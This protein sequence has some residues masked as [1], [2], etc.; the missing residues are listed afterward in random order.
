MQVLI[1]IADAPCH[2]K[3]FHNSSVGDVYPYGDPKG[4][5]L[6]NLMKKIADS[7]IHYYFGYINKSCTLLMI[8]AFNTSLQA[9]SGNVHSVQQ[10]DAQD[11]HK[12]LEGIYRSV[13]YSISATMD[14][15]KT[16]TKILRTYEID[17][18]IPKWDSSLLESKMVLITP[19]PTNGAAAEISTPSQGMKVKIAKQPF[20]EGAQKIVYHGF[21]EQNKTH[22]VLK[23]SRWTDERSNCIERCLEA[24]QIHAVADSFSA[25]FN[26]ERPDDAYEIQFSKVGVMQVTSKNQHQFFTYE[27]YLQ[28]SE[29]KKFDTN[30]YCLPGQTKELDNIPSATCQAFSH[31][32]W[33]KSGKK[34]IVCDLQGVIARSKL[35]L[36]D[37]VIHY[38][39]VNLGITG[40]EQFFK[41]HK[42]NNFCRK[43]KLKC[44]N[45]L[46]KDLQLRSCDTKL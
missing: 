12:L 38:T 15:L 45:D 44:P 46:L 10:F 40:I 7:A 32:T 23:Q 27:T 5:Q 6:D 22:I 42:C 34:L 13:T 37:P 16:G 28:E 11:P 9:V 29:Y 39:H 24:V 1:H 43:L 2:G 33:E 19:P 4:L 18:S 20:A 25:E 8:K 26:R 3:K 30:F 21:D 36:T 35:K 17:D 31:Y 14:V 41:T